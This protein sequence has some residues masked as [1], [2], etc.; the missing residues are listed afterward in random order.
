M[1][2]Q[3]MGEQLASIISEAQ[4]PDVYVGAQP[5]RL[6]VL[7]S[8]CL[9]SSGH[10][11]ISL[12]GVGQGIS[13][14]FECAHRLSRFPGVDVGEAS[15]RLMSR[16]PRNIELTCVDIP[17]AYDGSCTN[18]K[19]SWDI[20]PPD[21]AG[22]FA[23]PFPAT[24]MLLQDVLARTEQ[25]TVKLDDSISFDVYRD[26]SAGF[27][28]KSNCWKN[29]RK[30]D[31]RFGNS[32]LKAGV[33]M[34]PDWQ[35]VS[36][37][38]GE[39]DD[40]ILGV[41]TNILYNSV[42]TRQLIDGFILN[43]PVSHRMTPNWVLIVIPQAAV[44]ELEY[45]ANHRDAKGRLTPAGRQAFHAL[46]E[47]FQ[48]HTLDIAGLGII[49]CGELDASWEICSGIGLLRRDIC[50]LRND[51]MRLKADE[52]EAF[53][54]NQDF[55]IFLEK[56]F[57]KMSM[58]DASIRVQFREYLRN[59]QFSKGAY[60]ITSDRVNHGLARTES[61]Y[62][63]YYDND[64]HR[65]CKK[66][67][68]SNVGLGAH[69]LPDVT[70]DGEKRPICIRVTLARLLYD[71]ATEYGEMKISWT[72]EGQDQSINMSTDRRGELDD[73][74]DNVFHVRGREVIEQL[75]DGKYAGLPISKMIKLWKQGK[76]RINV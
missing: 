3:S 56:R 8:I 64:V 2:G 40:V 59:T 14:A 42:I 67:L 70:I 73:W 15:M 62:S 17:I 54:K 49:I 19:D 23:L 27:R 9:L 1:A 25:I 35:S 53:N 24:E 38:L 60:F 43:S 48:M 39:Y 37:A 68:E 7:K 28:I 29:T 72:D 33:V 74:I 58:S 4:K 66:A 18:K 31:Q 41:D 26:S 46:G 13:Q 52:V 44:S 22:M 71:L 21:V 11:E 6:S 51:F 65:K 61:M 55:R 16:Q 57:K 36:D 10:K 5:L 20:G 76:G 45:A 63:L 34:S 75:R 30:T 32:L 12:I 69:E 50:D 47:I